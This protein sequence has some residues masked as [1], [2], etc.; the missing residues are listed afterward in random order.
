M[1]VPYSNKESEQMISLQTCDIGAAS[2]PHQL[3][4]HRYEVFQ[5]PTALHI[6]WSGHSLC[7]PI[8]LLITLTD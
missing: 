4:I 7:F 8:L 3:A 1:R 6:R 2:G 5:K